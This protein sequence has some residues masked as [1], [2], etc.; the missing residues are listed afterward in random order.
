MMSILIKSQWS[1]WF[2]K[3]ALAIQGINMPAS[4]ICFTQY[5]L[6]NLIPIFIMAVIIYYPWLK[7]IHVIK[8]DPWC[9]MNG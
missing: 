1:M 4:K 3:V 9:L 5:T 6:S 7:L 8:M 2:C